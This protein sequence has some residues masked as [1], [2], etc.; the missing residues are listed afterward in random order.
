MGRRFRAAFPLAVLAAL[1]A[2]GA[3]QPAG[4]QAQPPAPGQPV[5]G[6][7]MSDLPEVRPAISL[8]LVDQP[9]VTVSF[10][11]D[12]GPMRVTGTLVDAPRRLLRLLDATGATRE[13]RWSDLFSLNVV[14]VPTAELPVGSFTV[15]LSSEE[16]ALPRSTAT[17]TTNYTAGATV[18]T[19]PPA[20]AHLLELPRGE[21]ILQGEPYNSLRIP[22][23]R[24]TDLRMEAIRGSLVNMPDVKISLEVREG[25]GN[26]NGKNGGQK[27]GDNGTPSEPKVIDIPLRRVEVFRRDAARQLLSVTLADGQIFT[28]RIVN[29]P[30]AAIEVDVENQTRSY[31]LTRIAQFETTIQILNRSPLT[32]P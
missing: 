22:T 15:M 12:Y 28:G 3:R 5:P 2:L 1:C 17:V 16:G 7:P 21:L 4:A 18:A 31:L 24:V 9:L 19:V 25:G 11:G 10:N 8:L 27:G 26:G 29:L 23:E 30:S 14:R 20:P 6:Q 32:S 13:I